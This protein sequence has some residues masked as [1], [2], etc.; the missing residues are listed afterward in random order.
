MFD[1]FLVFPDFQAN[2]HSLFTILKIYGNFIIY[3]NYVNR[4][5]ELS[6]YDTSVNL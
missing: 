4:T 1:L 2:K 6:E 3:Q 5:N